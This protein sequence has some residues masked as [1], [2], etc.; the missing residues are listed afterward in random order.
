M[1]IRNVTRVLL[2]LPSLCLLT[3][4]QNH[5]IH[6]WLPEPSIDELLA[7]AYSAGR[8]VALR[9]YGGEWAP[10]QERRGLSRLLLDR[11]Q[12]LLDAEARIAKTSE[13]RKDLTY[14]VRRGRIELLEGTYEEAVA[15][16]QSALDKEPESVDA[17]T[18]LATAY[19]ARAETGSKAD[20]FGQAFELQSRALRL[21]PNDAM[22]IFNR[23]VTGERL[24]L[25]RR[26]L[27]DWQLFLSL[28]PRGAWSDEGRLRLAELTHKVAQ[29]KARDADALL[30]PLQF[31][32]RIKAED[33]RT[34]AQVEEHVEEYLSLAVSRWLPAAFS[35]EK[36]S[37]SAK[38]ARNA[39]EVLSK[40]VKV[41]NRDTWLDN[42]IREA[43]RQPGSAGLI[44]LSEAVE[45]DRVTE[46]FQ[47]G[48]Q[49]ATEAARLFSASHN[50]AG[51]WRAEF[52]RIY[53][54]RLSDEGKACKT[55]VGDLVRVLQPSSY[56][57]LKIQAEI[58]SYECLTEL[59]D[60]GSANL[61]SDAR[62][63]ADQAD[64]RD[65]SL[66]ALD[67][68]AADLFFRGQ[69]STGWNVSRQGLDSYWTGSQ[70][71]TLGYDL[72]A[73]MDYGAQQSEWWF[74]DV[75][76]D[77]QALE[78]LSEGNNPLIKAVEH[79]DLARA[80]ISAGETEISRENLNIAE[81]LI[82]TVPETSSTVAYRIA[83]ESNAAL[84]SGISGKP[85]AGLDRLSFL[86]SQIGRNQNVN[87][88]AETYRISGKL[89]EARGRFTAAE[90]NLATAV[91]LGES[92]K[93]SI[94]S[95]AERVSWTRQWS[96]PYLDLID[97]EA[98]LGENE[99]A[100]AI[101]ELYREVQPEFAVSI[102][103][104]GQTFISW[105]DPDETLRQFEE[106]IRRRLALFERITTTD[107][108]STILVY[109][110]VDR[111][112][113]IWSIDRRG[114]VSRFIKANPRDVRMNVHQ[115]GELCSSPSSGM[116][117]V[118]PYSKYLYGLL[119][120]PIADRLLPGQN[121]V[122][123]TDEALAELPFQVLIGE[124]DKYFVDKHALSYL[125]DL[126][127]YEARRALPRHHSR[128]E[129][130]LIVASTAAS[131]GGLP[132]LSDAITEAEA[133]LRLYPFGKLLSGSSATTKEVLRQLPQ[134]ELFHFAGHA[135]GGNG[136][137]G[138]LLADSMENENTR[139]LSYGELRTINLARLQLAVLSA[140][141][142][143]NGAEG[144]PEDFDS[145]VRILL[146]KGV[147]NVVA[148]RWSV[149]S[150]SS[151]MLMQAFYR[152]VS[153]GVTIARALAEAEAEIRN[154]SDRPYFWA[155]FDSFGAD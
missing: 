33:R 95:E 113:L 127:Y 27:Q 70:N 1:K 69:T 114:V 9:L 125:P 94:T 5:Q 36:R 97:C 86:R 15:D 7:R 144:L 90:R 41:A 30:A 108:Q 132:P 58:E 34:W 152:R 32:T 61:L 105:T 4:V 91:A 133:V 38:E 56:T 135:Y 71:S 92:V 31:V 150:E 25:Y 72:Y 83:V 19:F 29:R 123:E 151:V 62:K 49:K 24:G 76:I 88:V 77:E 100:L 2:L 51:E 137:S 146:A 67:F 28:Q 40:I 60:F 78:L 39:L 147:S 22:L 112:V 154:G 81:D 148:S 46:N 8:P 129:A 47:L 74:L 65:L 57:W 45:A 59:G 115:L 87:L 20:G 68:L 75:A 11:S 109:A 35:T 143:E 13:Q 18:D 153:Q 138:L 117:V 130:A 98:E 126:T 120:E 12:P 121:I 79:T 102:Q 122:I 96:K 89:E 142:T 14:F 118:K 50:L 54:L 106:N 48:R 63:V 55:E 23:A 64:Y 155:A 107:F 128:I 116:R 139:L 52:E 134:A 44:A 149:N 73:A 6:L 110:L 66:R 140:C 119:I 124:D 99:K 136:K 84:V 16:L 10:I 21:S 93:R 145:L 43:K 53:A 103:H 131:S 80:A 141:S 101:W 104:P 3:P 37:R 42:M 85:E 111:G 82:K 26:S 17:L